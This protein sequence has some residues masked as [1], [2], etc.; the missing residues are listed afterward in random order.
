MEMG[1]GEQ[2]MQQRQMMVFRG[3]LYR[4][5]SQDPH[6]TETPGGL[7]PPSILRLS[8]SLLLLNKIFNL[9]HIKASYLNSNILILRV[10]KLNL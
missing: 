8:P 3:L 9:K 2:S 4:T 6:L 10:G 7:P 1:G 5:L